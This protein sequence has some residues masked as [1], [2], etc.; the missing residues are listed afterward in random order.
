MSMFLK[1]VAGWLMLLGVAQADMVAPDVLVRDTAQDVV[2]IIKQD[3]DIKAGDQQKL[4]ALVDAKILPNFDFVRMTQLAVGMYWKQASDAQKQAL[5]TEFRN[6]LVRT[7]TKAFMAYRDQK[8]DVAPIKLAPEDDEVTVKMRIIKSGAPQATSVDYQLK[9]RQS[10]WKVFDVVIEGVSMVTSYRGTF[11]SEINK[12]GID[13][14]IKT[15]MDS[16]AKASTTSLRKA[17]AK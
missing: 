9:K 6:L 4:L 3:A 10:G 13:G 16:N 15:L 12:S 11:A 2:R 17:D 14:L 8:I 5:V 7:Y 1:V